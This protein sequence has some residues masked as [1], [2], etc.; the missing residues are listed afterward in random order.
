MHFLSRQRGSLYRAKDNSLIQ[1][2][3]PL[4]DALLKAGIY[5]D[6]ALYQLALKL[7]GE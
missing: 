2:V 3:K 5:L 1:E 6:N 4:L 7:A